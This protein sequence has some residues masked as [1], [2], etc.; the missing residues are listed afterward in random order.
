MKKIQIPAVLR[1]PIYAGE[2][3]LQFTRNRVTYESELV[4]RQSTVES[5]RL[6]LAG[7]IPESWVALLGATTEQRSVKA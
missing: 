3:Q 2:G 1:V 4:S 5:R 6:E 7:T